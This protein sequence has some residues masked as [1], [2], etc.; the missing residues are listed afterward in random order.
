MIHLSNYLAVLDLLPL[1]KH[2]FFWDPFYCLFFF[3]KIKFWDVSSSLSWPSTCWER[4]LGKDICQMH[5]SWNVS[6]AYLTQNSTPVFSY[7]RS[8]P[9]LC[10]SHWEHLPAPSVLSIYDFHTQPLNTNQKCHLVLSQRSNHLLQ[11]WGEDWGGVRWP[12]ERWHLQCPSLGKCPAEWKC[13]WF[14]LYML[15]WEPNPE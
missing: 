2:Y 8:F 14:L 15:T 6:D 3:P 1:F 11:H 4:I 7:L 10:I 13:V 5:K 12:F 9:F